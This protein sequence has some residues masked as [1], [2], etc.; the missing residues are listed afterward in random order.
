[1]K[2]LPFFRIL[3][4]RSAD[5]YNITLSHTFYII[6]YVYLAESQKMIKF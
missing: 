3:H 4:K 2:I 1:M 6:I 5:L